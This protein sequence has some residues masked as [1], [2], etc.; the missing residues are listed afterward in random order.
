DFAPQLQE[1]QVPDPYYGGKYG[2]ERVL[3]MAEAASA[4]F[5]ESL[6][7]AGQVPVYE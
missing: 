3:D 7:Q 2:F 1:R 6:Q 4:G 5:L